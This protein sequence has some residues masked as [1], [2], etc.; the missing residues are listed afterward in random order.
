MRATR[1]E[2]GE[3]L[4]ALKGEDI[5]GGNTVAVIRVRRVTEGSA[6]AAPLHCE[7]EID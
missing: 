1:G 6:A 4:V 7:P 3:D 2:P 5:E